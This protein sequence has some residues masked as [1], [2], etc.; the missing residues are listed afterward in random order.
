MVLY[1]GEKRGD[2]TIEMHGQ[3]TAIANLSAPTDGGEVVVKVVA[4]EGLEPPTRG[5]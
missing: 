5:L 4:E 3:M 1:P 2:L